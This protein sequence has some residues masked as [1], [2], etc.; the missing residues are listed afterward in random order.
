MDFPGHYMRRI[1]SVSITLPCV[2]GPYASVSATLRLMKSRIRYK[3]ETA[4]GY[5]PRE[6]D[7]R[8]LTNYAATRAVATSTG[9]NE[10][11]LFELN[12]RDERYLPFEGEG[13][14]SLWQLEI[15][16][17]YAGFDIHT[18]SDS[19]LHIRYTAREGGETLKDAA[20][21]RRARR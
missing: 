12:F 13:V 10:S 1:K 21:A 11:G 16:K 8:F 20:K 19:V 9:Q 18:L 17:D 6:D 3:P 4:V 2:T 15:N 5:A 14:E 7:P